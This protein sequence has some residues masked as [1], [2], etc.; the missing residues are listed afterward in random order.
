[1]NE[2]SAQKKCPAE[3]AG[4]FL[5]GLIYGLKLN[6]ISCSR[7]FGSFDNVELNAG[8]F[9]KRFESLGLDSCVMDEYVFATILLDKTKSL[10]IVKPFY[11]TF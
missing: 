6:Y 3:I 1:M 10:S 7:A 5:V 8:T 2:S 4:H 9:I 11:C